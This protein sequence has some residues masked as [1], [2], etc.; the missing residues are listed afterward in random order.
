M[1]KPRKA[2]E[3][4]ETRASLDILF[5][6]SR[7]LASSLDLHTVL[8]RVLTLS[9]SNM[10][11]ER[12]SLVVLDES[13]RPVDA[14]IIYDGKLM[15]NTVSQLQDV[16]T[17]GLAGWVIRNRQPV[18]VTNT[19]RDSRWLIRNSD[20]NAAQQPKSALCV[21]LMAQDQLV[22]V[23][24]IVH[25][26]EGFFTQEDL[27][28]Q[29][30]I[31]DLSGLA[32]RNAQLYAY[33]EAVNNRYHE[34]FEDSIDPILI[35]DLEGRILE[36]NHKAELV[37][38]YTEAELQL[39]S[40][41]DLHEVKTEST[42]EGFEAIPNVGTIS[43][44][45]LLNCANQHKLPIEVYISKVTTLGS[46][47]IQWILRDIEVRKDLDTLRKDLTAM[48]YHDLRSPLANIIS[49][50]EILST[51]LPMEDGSAIKA[52]YQVANRSTDRMQRLINSLLDIERIEAGQ[53]ITEKSFAGVEDLISSAIEA[54]A[55]NI[56]SKHQIVEKSL[57]PGLPDVQVDEDMI[58]RVL[59]NLIENA[60]KY[61]PSKSKIKV[62]ADR[63]EGFVRFTVDDNGP[64]IPDG[65][66]EHIFD[67]FSRVNS[68]STR[69]GLGIGLAF[70]RLAVIAHGGK[71]WVENLYPTGSRFT[72]TIPVN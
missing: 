64:G 53:Q 62:S 14:A 36:V 51:L 61:S 54:T 30:V 47:F 46:P 13:A 59:I 23:L 56:E 49:S 50:L 26:G 21:P 31:A 42:G 57:T 10:G 55:P 4:Q 39:M 27:S 17:D 20:P 67:K 71:I 38:G 70:C 58:K 6:I 52:V 28:L 69:K 29:Q 63:V 12:A 32:I 7:E 66:E 33:S 65:F 3:L 9:T 2:M 37:S 48:I 16:A 34:L 44:E 11:A 18:L 15:S 22:G 5:N 72:F 19:T 24:T 43:Y 45:S 40:I 35:T 41:K 25:P 68:V 60:S 1:I 8:S